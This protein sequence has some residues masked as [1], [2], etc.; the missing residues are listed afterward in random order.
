MIL[1]ITGESDTPG[2]KDYTKAF[3]P[4]AEAF[5]KLALSADRAHIV[6]FDNRLGFAKRWPQLANRLTAVEPSGMVSSVAIF[7]HGWSDGIQAGL[8]RRNVKDFVKLLQAH[9]NLAPNL[10]VLLYCCS[11]GNDPEDDLSEAPGTVYES[12]SQNLGEGSFADTLR[13][14]L[15][16]QGVAPDCRVVAHRTAGHTTENPHVIM[17]DGMGSAVGGV[18]GYM[19]VTPRNKKLWRTWVKFL[20]TSFHF[21]FPYMSIDEI[22]ARVLR[23]SSEKASR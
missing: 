3:K 7:C 17:F 16:K 14:E 20:K 1:I 19:P 18:G 6:T 5:Y 11:T 21:E 2:K 4:S 22:H 12:L 13:D 15:C 9:F 23:E 10:H 8:T